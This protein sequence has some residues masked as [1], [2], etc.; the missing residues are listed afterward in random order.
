MNKFQCILCDIDGTIAI[1]GDRGPHDLSLV[2]EDAPRQNMARILHCLSTDFYLIYLSGRQEHCRPATDYWLK[3]HNFPPG[4]AL[5]MRKDKDNRQDALVKAEIFE[6]KILP[7]YE[8]VAVLDDRNQVVEM[9]RSKGL[10]C[11]QVDEGN[12]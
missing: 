2:I 4:H 12:F 10:L 8:V 7:H 1:R 9:W 5:F 3:T 11:L 6:E